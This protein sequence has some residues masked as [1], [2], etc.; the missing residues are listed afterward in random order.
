TARRFDPTQARWF[1][2][3]PTGRYATK[4]AGR[5]AGALY[6][7]GAQ[8]SPAVAL[9]TTSG[10]QVTGGTDER[11]IRSQGVQRLDAL[12]GGY[13]D[14]APAAISG[15]VVVEFEIGDDG[16]VQSARGRGLGGVGSCVAGIISSIQFAP[17]ERETRA[18]LPMTFRPG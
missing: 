12:V 6:D 9:C 13:R 14:P 16:R 8:G 2:V 1:T 11:S 15:E 3:V 10:C 18:R 7:P 4:S 5:A 17:A